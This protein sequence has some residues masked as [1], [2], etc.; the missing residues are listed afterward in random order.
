MNRAMAK[1]IAEVITT[2]QLRGMFES[3]K[4]ETKDWGKTSIV[5]KGM[6]KGTAFNIL[7]AGDI[8]SKAHILAKTNMIR[9]FGEFLPTE[10]LPVRATKC[11]PDI[12]PVHQ[13]PKPLN[14]D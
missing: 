13:D 1:Q 14:W 11:N 8:S 9:E 4:N 2:D 3:A 7:S 12:K 6:T 10:L 5:N